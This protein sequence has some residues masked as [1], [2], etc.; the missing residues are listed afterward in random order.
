M[1]QDIEQQVRK[2]I[3]EVVVAG[4]DSSTN[5][6][7]TRY[8]A[9]DPMLD[10]LGWNQRDPTQVAVEYSPAKSQVRVD[11]ALLDRKRERVFIEAKAVGANLDEAKNLEQLAS[12]SFLGDNPLGVLTDGH[13]WLLY[14]PSAQGSWEERCFAQVDVREDAA[15]AARTLARYLSR[16]ATLSGDAY[17]D[18]REEQ[19][20][21]ARARRAKDELERVNE[22]MLTEPD[23]DLVALLQLKVSEETGEEQH[24]DDVAAFL[25]SRAGNYT[26]T[27]ET[28]QISASSARKSAA[29]RKSTRQDKPKPRAVV[30]DGERREVSRW[31]QV[32]PTVCEMLHE[33]EPK[34]FAE[35]AGTKRSWSE[36]R[37]SRD[38]RSSFSSKGGEGELQRP[39]PVG[40]TGWYV[41]T[42]LVQEKMKKSAEALVRD[43]LG[44]GAKL[45]IELIT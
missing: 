13:R 1:K 34:R 23:A 25:R 16:E 19:E 45:K 14:I 5:E 29:K 18:A 40:T 44:T 12:Y 42:N 31:N 32:L 35:V 4:L 26:R 10:A 2:A 22:R 21:K 39:K 43:V 38:S 41:E 8:A 36:G 28:R 15:D 20:R 24:A 6:L 30:L 7:Q 11:Y 27:Y 17:R 3:D 9:I 37:L 33:R